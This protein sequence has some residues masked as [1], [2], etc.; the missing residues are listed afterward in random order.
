[1]LELQKPYPKVEATASGKNTVSVMSTERSGSRNREKHRR[2]TEVRSGELE[3]TR[4][5]TGRSSRTLSFRER[6]SQQT[7]HCNLV[8]KR[9]CP[10]MTGGSNDG[11]WNPNLFGPW[12]V[13]TAL[14]WAKG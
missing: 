1:M 4:D 12:T 6:S 3:K 8:L 7:E 14:R 5:R 10:R 9:S 13:L 2:A 11:G